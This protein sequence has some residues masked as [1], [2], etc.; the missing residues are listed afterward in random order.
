VAALAPRPDRTIRVLIVDDSIF[1]RR[2]LERLLAKIPGVVV[3]G[4]AA[5]GIEGVKLALELRPDVITMDV[6]MPRM[7]GLAAVAEIMKTIPTPIVMV[8]TM[9]AAGAETTLRAL[10]AGAVEFITKPSGLGHELA[11]VGEQ[12]AGALARAS[13]ARVYRRSTTPLGVPR[14]PRASKTFS[15]IPAPQVVVIGSSTGGPPAL[16]AIVPLLHAD[17]P[18]CV[19]VVQHMPSGF[20]AALA[21]RL[22]SVSSIAVSEAAEG[23]VA[24]PGRVLIAPGGYH[25]TIGLDRRIHLD[26]GPSAHGVRPS[27]DV[28]LQSLPGVYG[29][30]VTVAIL[31]GMGKDG[32]EGCARVE[33]AGGTV[34]TQ[35]EATCVV[36]GMPRAAKHRTNRSREAPV[37]AIATLLLSAVA[38]AR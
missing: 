18:A 31:T 5:D 19:L 14:P 3:I 25:M 35:D 10:D 17:L 36:Y 12:L 16:T 13:A 22:D 26:Q 9:T 1:M 6:E 30:N 24:S 34:V 2:S 11:N 33:E 23:D 8:S 20:T 38:G 7:D 27:V 21:R 29:R 15:R 32:A 28:T 4:A 37:G